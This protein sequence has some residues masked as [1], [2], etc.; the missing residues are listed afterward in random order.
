MGNREWGIG[1]RARCAGVASPITHHPSPSWASAAHRK[2]CCHIWWSFFRNCHTGV[3]PWLNSSRTTPV[4][5]I[6]AI[7]MRFI[8]QLSAF[9]SL[10]RKSTR[11]NSSHLGISYAVFCLK[12][13]KTK[14]E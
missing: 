11:L 2:S 1:K 14:D 8:V 12:K 10:D 3:P 6:D 9:Q 5:E 13:K 7:T 4:D